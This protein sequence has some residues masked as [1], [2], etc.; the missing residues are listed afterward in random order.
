MTTHQKKTSY[1]LIAYVL[2]FSATACS[3]KEH[4]KEAVAPKTVTPAATA[5]T[6]LPPTGEPQYIIK[7]VQISF[8]GGDEAPPVLKIPAPTKKKAPVKVTQKK[9]STAGVKTEPKA[10]APKTAESAPT[11]K[12]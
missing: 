6:S 3:S 12:N 9:P 1:S 4:K 2:F 10:V 7:D 11:P 8:E 5:P